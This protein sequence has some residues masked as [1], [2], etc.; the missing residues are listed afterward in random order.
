MLSHID[1]NGLLLLAIGL[2][3]RYIVGYLRFNRR[4]LAGLQIYSSYFKGIIC[5]SLE[6]LINICG[7]LMVVAGAILILIKM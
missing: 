3:I 5:K 4:N 6:A 2:L 1:T 7:L